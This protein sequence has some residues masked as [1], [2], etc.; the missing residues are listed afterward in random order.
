MNSARKQWSAR[1]FLS[2]AAVGVVLGMAAC[3]TTHQVRSIQGT[4][5]FLLDYEDMRLGTNGE[6]HLI[7]IDPNADWKKYDKVMIDRVQLWRGDESDSPLG[8]LSDEEKQMLVD[9]L[10]SALKE[11][12]SAD[13]QIVDQPGPGVMRLR[14]AITEARKSWPVLNVVSSVMPIGLGISFA[15][16]VTLGTHTATGLVQVEAEML[17]SQTNMRLFA[18]VD[19]RSGTKAWRT[20]LSGRWVDV[21]EAFDYWARR[22]QMRLSEMRMQPPTQS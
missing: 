5:G 16:R 2:I 14:S 15:K 7:Y 6:A 4:S 1:A 11:S 3:A 8:Q 12:L 9:N 17:D 22:L 13:Y 19:R 20:K 21:R 10:Y 18:A